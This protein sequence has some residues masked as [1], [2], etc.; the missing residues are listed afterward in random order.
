MEDF[1]NQYSK[2]D[3]AILQKI[4]ELSEKTNPVEINLG[5]LTD[6]NQCHTGIVITKAPGVIIRSIPI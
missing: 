1:M 6:A 2:N 5:Y 4:L 3:Q